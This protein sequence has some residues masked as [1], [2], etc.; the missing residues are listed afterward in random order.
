VKLDV[1]SDIV[2]VVG[3]VEVGDSGGGVGASSPTLKLHD[4][5]QPKATTHSHISGIII[6]VKESSKDGMTGV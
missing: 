6:V 2:G 3:G 4:P 5:G 1:F